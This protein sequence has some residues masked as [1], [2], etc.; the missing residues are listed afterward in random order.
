MHVSSIRRITS[1]RR[2]ENERGK[3][4][5]EGGRAGGTESIMDCHGCVLV[6]LSFVFLCNPVHDKR[7]PRCA[8]VRGA[9]ESAVRDVEGALSLSLSLSRGSL[10]REGSRTDE[11]RIRKR[12]E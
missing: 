3:K 12:R 5:G 6:R 11:K 4:E 1:L 8:N 2:T 7:A 10:G 9:L